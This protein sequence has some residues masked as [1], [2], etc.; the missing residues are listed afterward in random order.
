VGLFLGW[1]NFLV[2]II[3]QKLHVTSGVTDTH[4]FYADPFLAFHF[5]PDPDPNPR[6]PF[7]SDT[8]PTFN[9]MRIRILPFTFSQIW[10][11]QCSKINHL[12]TQKRIRIQLSIVMRIRAQLNWCGSRT[13]VTRY[14]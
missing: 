12:V 3:K 4:H 5:D 9:L 1:I 10:T 2:P 14:F 13:L 6:V 11:L 7:Y 8:D